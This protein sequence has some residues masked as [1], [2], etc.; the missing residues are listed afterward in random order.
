MS[1]ARVWRPC[2]PSSSRIRSPMDGPRKPLAASSTARV[3]ATWFL[4]S[5]PH[6]RP[7]G[8]AR[9]R[10]VLIC[11]RP[12]ADSMRS[13]LLAIEDANGG[14]VVRTRT[15]ALQIHTRQWIG[16]YAGKGRSEEHTSELQSPVHLVCRLL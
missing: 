12:N 13:V 4:T 7:H 10:A 16:T 5:M 3:A 6:A 14:E 1:I 15:T 2:V 8:S 9:C 11:Q